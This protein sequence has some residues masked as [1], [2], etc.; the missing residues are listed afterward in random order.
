MLSSLVVNPLFYIITIL[1]I[2]FFIK[3]KAIKWGVY[4]FATIVALLF[5]C[6][7][8]LQYTQ[9]E[10]YREYDRPL[11]E[12]VVYKYGIVLGGYSVWD[13]ERKRPEHSDASDR[14]F[15][16][17][18]LYKMGK[19][20]KLLLASDGSIIDCE[21]SMGMRGNP[22]E[23]K[24]YLRIFG[25]P[26]KDIILETKAWNTKENAIFTRNLLQNSNEKALLI[27]SALH[28]RRSDAAFRKAG[29]YADC[30]ITDVLVKVGDGR[31]SLVPSLRTLLNWQIVLHEVIGYVVY[32]MR[33]DI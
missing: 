17:I 25:V 14:L 9:K 22:E 8:L 16:G 1:C 2:G 3:R 19:I 26:E 33:G 4:A 20:E 12:G 7:A 10:W 24:E 28:M 30:Y 23:M 15:E 21:N 18:R 5:S 11:P 27:T 6:P 13:H 29:V 32:R 31:P